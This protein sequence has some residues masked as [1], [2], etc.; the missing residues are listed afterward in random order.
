LKVE[1]NKTNI[2]HVFAGLN[3]RDGF[4]RNYDAMN[5]IVGARRQEW[6]VGISY[7]INVS[8]LSS[9]THYRGAFELS[10]IY[11]AKSSEPS[12]FIVPCDL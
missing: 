3:Y 5:L 12:I 8:D 11:I 4:N 1:D 9:V 2:D 7:D 6:Q 10:V